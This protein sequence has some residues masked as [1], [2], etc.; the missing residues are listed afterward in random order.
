MMA[1]FKK[2]LKN[3][4][5]KS[6]RASEVRG[7]FAPEQGK[8]VAASSLE[9][10]EMAFKPL[11]TS[12]TRKTFRKALNWDSWKIINNFLNKYIFYFGK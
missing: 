1:I 5:Q 3:E 7:N 8:A 10:I 4:R 11:K 9:D 6:G 2:I 12:I